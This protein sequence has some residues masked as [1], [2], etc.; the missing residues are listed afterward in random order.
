VTSATGLR[1]RPG[2][3]GVRAVA[4]LAVL[5]YHGQVGWAR[6]GF[7]GVDIFFVLSGFLITGL[8]VA[9]WGRWGSID[10]RRFWLRR[11]RRLLPA[12]F[13]VLVAV[14]LG[15]AALASPAERGTVRGDALATLGYVANWRFVLADRSY[16]AQYDE[17]S[18]LRHMWSLGI[19]EQFYLIFPL[20]LLALLATVG[21]R[22]R[23]L[24]VA[25]GVGAAAS[26][27]LAAAL[28]TPAPTRP[29]CTTARTRG[30]RRCW[31]APSQPCWPGT[32]W[33]PGRPRT[34]PLPAATSRCQAAGRRGC[35]GWPGSPPW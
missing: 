29:G 24:A 35:S 14:S 11:A 2:L 19:E 22:R 25:F 21:L 26:A 27:A 5:L 6:G 9:E 3:D 23:V 13:L 34:C 16:F 15:A 18:P 12:L 1:Y 4:V 30:W 10:L 32:G 33:R 20:L 8:L 31:S 28:Y 17:P 7:V